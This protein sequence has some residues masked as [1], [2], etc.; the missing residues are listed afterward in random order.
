MFPLP[1]SIKFLAVALVLGLGATLASFWLMAWLIEPDGALER[2]RRD[3]TL[4]EFVRLKEQNEL[5][6]RT[7]RDELEPPQKQAPPPPPESTFSTPEPES[8]EPVNERL[9]LDLDL[10]FSGEGALGDAAVAGS[11][12]FAQRGLTPVSGTPP[13]YPRRAR[14]MRV[15]G[16]VE[17][18]FTITTEGTVKD[19]EVIDSENGEH[20]ERAAVAA[21]KRWRFRPK[22]VG[23]RPVEQRAIQSFEFRLDQ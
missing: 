20:F 16:A 5:Q 1:P 21:L 7:R 22:L 18:I 8:L 15:E 14:M 6:T 19:I 12:G 4:V 17:L 2:D 23:G 10:T 9:S 3:R 13:Q 11:M